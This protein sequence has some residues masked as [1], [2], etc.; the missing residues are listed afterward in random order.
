[1]REAHE[2]VITLLMNS[3]Y[4]YLHFEMAILVERESSSTVFDSC[5]E[6]CMTSRWRLIFGRLHSNEKD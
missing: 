5:L 4:V 6:I 3:R 1:M 2:C